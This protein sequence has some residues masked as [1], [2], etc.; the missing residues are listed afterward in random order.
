MLHT[1]TFI[2]MHELAAR[3]MFYTG[4]QVYRWFREHVETAAYSEAVATTPTRTGEMS[5]QNWSD[6]GANQHGLWV[7]LGN[8]APYSLYVHE[9]TT[10]PIEPNGPF[11]LMGKQSPTGAGYPA[12]MLARH[13]SGQEAQPWMAEAAA[14]ALQVNGFPATAGKIRAGA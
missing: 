7:Q 11:L 5:T 6:M 12:F 2:N 1:H 10:G 9:G 14:A 13:V 3:S 4:G 8:S